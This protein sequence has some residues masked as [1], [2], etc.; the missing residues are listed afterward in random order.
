M[1]TN[2]KSALVLTTSKTGTSDS[3]SIQPFDCMRCKDLAQTA[4][5]SMKAVEFLNSRVKQRNEKIEYQR[6]SIAKHK[7]QLQIQKDLVDE[8]QA[9]IERLQRE[10]KRS[11]Q[12][13]EENF[14][15]Q[16][17]KVARN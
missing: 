2:V 13:W 3:Q 14:K 15:N 17:L 9:V 5:E 16:R 7:A 6:Q 1:G 4:K 12:E 11:T 10:A 8:R